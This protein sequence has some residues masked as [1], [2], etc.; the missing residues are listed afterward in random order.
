[1]RKLTPT[2]KAAP[3]GDTMRPKPPEMTGA[4]MLRLFSRKHKPRDR[5]WKAA[6]LLSGFAPAEALMALPGVGG[7]TALEILTK[8][9]DFCVAQDEDLTIEGLRGIL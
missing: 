5:G 2:A 4:Q 1:M 7:L 8:V 9:L 6:N 3:L